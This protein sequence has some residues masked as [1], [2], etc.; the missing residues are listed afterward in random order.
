MFRTVLATLGALALAP[1][2]RRASWTTPSP[3]ARSWHWYK[4]MDV[5]FIPDMAA[6]G[7]AIVCDHFEPA[8]RSAGID[9]AL[10]LIHE[11]GEF[12]V[13]CLLPLSRGPD[14]RQ[15]QIS[16]EAANFWTALVDHAGGPG[17]AARVFEEYCA[18]VEREEQRLV[19]RH[20]PG[21]PL[22]W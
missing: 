14:F 6:R 8:V 11:G 1:I 2:S 9:E 17:E 13:T 12:H 20:R 18:L 4:M 3:E 7:I 15:M 22:N 21:G 16:P 10:F 5:A 19:K